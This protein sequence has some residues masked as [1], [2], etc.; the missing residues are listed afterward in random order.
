MILWLHVLCGVGWVG[1]CLS[2][3]LAAHA[4]AGRRLELVEFIGRAAPRVNR[5]GLGCAILIPLTGAGNLAFVASRRR[6]VLPPEFIAIVAAKMLLFAL[7]GWTLWQAA[8][9]VPMGAEH[10]DSDRDERPR[11]TY[12]Y[13][14]ITVC[15]AM[16]LLLGL[17]LSG[18]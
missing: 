3:I 6:F 5:M 11:L 9:I 13:G 15:G 4:L 8:L 12:C 14:L 7:M 1:A 17:W 18:I 16:A 2:F 10:P